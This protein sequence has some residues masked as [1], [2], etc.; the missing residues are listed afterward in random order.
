[1]RRKVA[2]PLVFLFGLL[3]AAPAS[4]LFKAKSV[5]GNL[6]ADSNIETVQAERVPDPSDP[7]D[8]TLA[9]TAVEVVDQ[10]GRRTRSSRC[11]S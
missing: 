5:S 3:A 8:D 9:Q 1:M 4:G 11:A 7:S 10:C 6:D 2:L